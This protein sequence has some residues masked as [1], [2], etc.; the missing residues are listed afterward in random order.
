MAGLR[1]TIDTNLLLEYWKFHA[2]ANV[3]AEL[4]RMAGQDK[5]DL[6]ITARV[7]EDIPSEPLASQLNMLSELHI[8]EISS[9]ARLGYWVL[10]RDRLGSEAFEQ[11]HNETNAKRA[12][13]NKTVEWQD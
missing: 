13:R 7:R 3:V 11:F 1:I 5:I 6:A 4:L 9:V 2:K 10:G 12:N 8:Q